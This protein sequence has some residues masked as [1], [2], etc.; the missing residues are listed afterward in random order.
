MRIPFLYI[1]D[2]LNFFGMHPGG[3]DCSMN[4]LY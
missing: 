4:V 3:P 1:N 2:R